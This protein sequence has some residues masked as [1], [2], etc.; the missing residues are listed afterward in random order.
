MKISLGEFN[1][2]FE[3]AEERMSKL[4]EIEIE[5]IQYEEQRDH[6]RKII[7]ALETCGTS[8]GPLTY[9]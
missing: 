1:S 3:V 6:G 7:R 5:I 2:R 9:L 4:E 8:S